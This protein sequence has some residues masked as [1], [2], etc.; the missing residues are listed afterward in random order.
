MSA[1]I[2]ASANS[3]IVAIGARDGVRAAAFAQARAIPRSYGSYAEL[4]ADPDVDVVYLANTH[5]QHHEV[6]L[7]TFRAGKPAL[8]EK[9]FTLTAWQAREV[10]TAAR[11]RELFCMEAMW[12]RL[13]PLIVKARE[14]ALSGQIG[15][16]TGVRADLCKVFPY[17]PR[18]RLFDV[19]AG[20][21]ALLDLGVYPVNFVWMI[22]GRP[23]TVQAVATLSSTGSDLLTAM[24]WTYGDGRVAQLYCDAHSESPY[25]GLINATKGWIRLETRLHHPSAMTIWTDDGNTEVIAGDPADDSFAAEVAEVERCLR[26][27]LT[28]SPAV[29]L[30]DTIAIMELLDDVRR[31]TGVHYPADD[32][33]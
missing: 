3:E 32:E 21:G 30:D 31:Q 10:V 20:G 17:D 26:T 8:I 28:E 1:D 18:H 7:Q 9:A 16:V 5:A 6:A 27:G 13:N 23:S 12:M 25:T 22:M 29:P 15:D 2:M 19:A 24:Q 14:I 4:L 33:G 11:E